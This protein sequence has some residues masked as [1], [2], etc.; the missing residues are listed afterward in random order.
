VCGF[1]V[2]SSLCVA[3]WNFKMKVKWTLFSVYMYIYVCG[4][5]DQLYL[6][7]ARN[8]MLCD[9]MCCCVEWWHVF[10]VLVLKCISRYLGLPECSEFHQWFHLWV[11]NNQY[12]FLSISGHGHCSGLFGIGRC[13]FM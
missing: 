9:V 6:F 5:T 8:D 7:V 1:G 10:L 2:T 13:D 3:T 11:A 12:A 4:R